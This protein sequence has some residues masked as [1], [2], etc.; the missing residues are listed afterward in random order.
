MT[1]SD[2]PQIDSDLNE[3]WDM[4]ITPRKKWYELQLRDVW[5]YRDLIELFVRRDFVA[6]YKQTI[7]GPLW[8][9]LQPL[10][11]TLTFT[12][13]F[14]NIARLPTD[15][16]PQI[17]FY[18]SGT[19]MWGYFSS[20]L[21][22]TSN[23]FTS[24]AHLFGKVYFP[25][26]VTPISIIISSLIT[27]A[28]QF[29]FFLCFMIYFLLRGSDIQLTAWALTLPLLIVLMAGLGLGFGIII[30]SLT[31]KYRDL[32]NLVSFG[33]SLLMY[34]T[35]VIYPV[36]SIPEELRWVADINP[37]TPIV[38]MFRAGFLGAGDVSWARLAYSAGFM[39]VVVFIGV[40]IFNR[41]EKTFIDTV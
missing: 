1:E 3:P 35:P 9:I 8:F 6:R 38:E 18:M 25:R 7:L 13:V 12:V 32:Q 23:T 4:V 33:V 2:I 34:F 26:L 28:I 19:V 16:L 30:S 11:T 21:T 24:N 31:T 36:S 14:G 20:C 10:L 39:L 22:G 17:L 15:G 29:G 37:I 5:R 40:V 41:V 27:F